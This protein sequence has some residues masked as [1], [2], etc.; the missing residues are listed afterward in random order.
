[1]DMFVGKRVPVDMFLFPG[2]TVCRTYVRDTIIDI[3]EEE[4]CHQQ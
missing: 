2:D 4:L 1:M 3:D